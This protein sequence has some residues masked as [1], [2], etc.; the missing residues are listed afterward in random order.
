MSCTFREIV[1]QS[2]VGDP[3]TQTAENRDEKQTSFGP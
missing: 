2:F 1:F 3:Q